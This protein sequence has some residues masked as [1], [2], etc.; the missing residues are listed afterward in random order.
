MGEGCSLKWCVEEGRLKKSTPGA[1]C[2]PGKLHF[3]QN[4]G[5][6]V[7]QYG[8]A[9]KKLF[10]YLARRLNAK[11]TQKK[12][13]IPMQTAYSYTHDNKPDIKRNQHQMLQHRI[14]WRRHA[15]LS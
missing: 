8:K 13:S 1:R 15:G 4:G 14:A 2:V 5:G 10:P 12:A 11:K 7:C 3:S 6:L 9:R